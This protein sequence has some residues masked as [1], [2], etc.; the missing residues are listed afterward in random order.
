MHACSRVRR[1]YARRVQAG[2]SRRRS[3]PIAGAFDV[4]FFDRRS[5]MTQ[6]A[7][8]PTRQGNR[9]AAL[10][11][12]VMLMVLGLIGVHQSYS[13]YRRVEAEAGS[14]CCNPVPE[15]LPRRR[16]TN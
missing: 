5:T 11:F 1:G 14:H 9:S 2:R 4:L 3:Q 6:D 15:R 7:K 10:L 13:D 12:A 16:A 8:S